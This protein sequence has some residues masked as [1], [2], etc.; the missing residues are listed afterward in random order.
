VRTAVYHFSKELPEED[1]ITSKHC[2]DLIK[3]GMQS[4]PLVF[5]D[6]C[7]EC[8]GDRDPGEKGLPL[9]DM[10]QHSW[11]SD[12]VEAYI[13]DNTKS[14]FRKTKQYDTCRDDGIAAFNNK[15]TYDDK[16]K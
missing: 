12:L 11:H 7:Y 15:L 8:D 6:K 16:L 10:N 13:L 14:H 5:V 2:L 1:Q 9:A 3:F 4:T